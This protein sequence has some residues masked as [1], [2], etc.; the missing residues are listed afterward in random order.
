[1]SSFYSVWEDG[2]V[3]IGDGV[4]SIIS[5]G[6]SASDALHFSTFSFSP[7]S[8]ASSFNSLVVAFF[9]PWSP[10]LH[11]GHA[12]PSWLPDVVHRTPPPPPG[13]FLWVAVDV[14]SRWHIVIVWWLCGDWFIYVA[15]PWT[16][17]LLS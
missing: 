13:P 15:F 3:P 14:A 17:I 9:W 6:F 5:H 8:E 4:G 1:M 10:V 11:R 7:F 2:L 16:F 12:I